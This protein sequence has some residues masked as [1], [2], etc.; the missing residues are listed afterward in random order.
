RLVRTAAS[1]SVAFG[2]YRR[3][4]TGH[5]AWSLVVLELDHE[6]IA[7]MTHFLDVEQVFP[8]FG[9]PLRALRSVLR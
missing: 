1:G 4:Q 6:R 3:S 8:R 7:S 2:Q 5:R 9:L